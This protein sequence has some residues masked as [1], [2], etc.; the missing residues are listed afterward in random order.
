MSYTT[1]SDNRQGDIEAAIAAGAAIES[2]DT[3]DG[4]AVL[5]PPG[6]KVED[7]DR[8]RMNPR[9]I[10]Q[11]VTV[12]DVDSLRRYLV[13]FEGAPLAVFADPPAGTFRAVLDYHDQNDDEGLVPRWGEHTCTL[14]L[15]KTP[16]WLTWTQADGRKM[17]QVD[18]AEFIE[19]HIEEIAA[20]PGAELLQ[21]VTDLQAA[22]NVEF[23]S[24]VDLDKGDHVFRFKSETRGNGE[25]HFPERIVLGLAPFLGMGAFAVDARLRY[26]VSDEGELTMWYQLLGAEEVLDKAAEE[27]LEAV[28]E[29]A[30]EER[31]FVG[32]LG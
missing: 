31:V 2:S 30:G 12:S 4:E 9:R 17:S 19:T 6:Y 24:K 3:L 18:L 13:R 15:T 23:V 26:R 22:R 1:L 8:F 11:R 27:A 10:S 20:P 16:E 29:I 28:R 5:V 32:R 25:V 7:I 14:Q 21:A